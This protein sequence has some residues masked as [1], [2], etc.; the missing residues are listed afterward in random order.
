MSEKGG[1]DIGQIAMIG[2]LIIA[3]YVGLKYL[4]PAL[5]SLN[6]IPGTVIS[7]ISSGIITPGVETG[8]AIVGGG[9]AVIDLPANIVTQNVPGLAKNTV[10]ILG[11]MKAVPILGGLLNIPIVNAVVGGLS[12]VANPVVSRANDVPGLI[13]SNVPGAGPFITYTGNKPV[14]VQGRGAYKKPGGM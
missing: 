13:S 2:A 4:L 5:K 1:I 14:I 12:Q 11:G 6:N 7:G 8:Q 10:D 9:A 3:G